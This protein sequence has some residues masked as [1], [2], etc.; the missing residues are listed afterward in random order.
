MS[1]LSSKTVQQANKRLCPMAW[2][3]WSPS[4]QGALQPRR[5]AAVSMS[6]AVDAPGDR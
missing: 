4:R 5:R 6:V 2:T 1:R 3:R